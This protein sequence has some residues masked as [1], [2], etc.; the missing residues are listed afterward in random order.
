MRRKSIRELRFID[1]NHHVFGLRWLLAR[2]G[3]YPNA[4]FHYRK[5]RKEKR[6]LRR[7]KVP[8]LIPELYHKGHGVDGYRP[9]T[10]CPARQGYRYSK[11]T[12][13]KDRDKEL[14]LKSIVRRKKP[15]YRKG[16]AHKVFEN[17]LGQN[18]TPAG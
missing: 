3:I 13:H 2:M 8:A 4:Y 6:K 7:K 12:R 11:A 9:V 10:I 15:D 14:S 5:H 18:F 17:K 16:K 1:R